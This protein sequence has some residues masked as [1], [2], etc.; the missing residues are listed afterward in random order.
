M[1]GPGPSGQAQVCLCH[2]RKSLSKMSEPVAPKYIER[3]RVCGLLLAYR[4]PLPNGRGTDSYTSRFPGLDFPDTPVREL[5]SHRWYSDRQTLCGTKQPYIVRVNYL[6]RD[7]QT[8]QWNG[9]GPDSL[10]G[11]ASQM[12]STEHSASWQ[13]T[14]AGGVWP[15]ANWVSQSTNNTPFRSR[16]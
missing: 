9:R 2:D 6:L 1:P 5:A 8:S 11:H 15:N 7:S 10:G 4:C 16:S 12:G 14:L 3:I 13:F